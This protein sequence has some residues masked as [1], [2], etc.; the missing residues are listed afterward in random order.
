M[1]TERRD[2]RMQQSEE[3]ATTHTP[4]PDLDRSL[5]RAV[6]STLDNNRDIDAFDLTVGVD[7]G[8]VEL[9]RSVG[10][11]SERMAAEELARGIPGVTRVENG[12]TVRPFGADWAIQ[13]ANIAATIHDALAA[14][15][16]AVDFT[17]VTYDVFCHVVTLDGTTRGAADRAR[18]RH[19]V[20][21]LPGVDFVRNRIEVES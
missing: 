10:S 8:T 6:R 12:V 9:G 4:R 18:V 19:V 1:S 20:E 14:I 11:Y 15:G 16:N 17:G 7:A 2:E 5:Y 21:Q 3:T 13:D